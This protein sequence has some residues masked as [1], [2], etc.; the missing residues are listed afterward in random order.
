MCAPATTSGGSSAARKVSPSRWL[1]GENCRPDELVL[2]A[3]GMAGP[4][5]GSDGSGLRLA[6]SLGHRLVEPV[7]ALVPLRLR[8]DFLRKLKGVRFDGRGELR[9]GGE[10]LGSEA[11][12]FLFT[13]S[14]IS[15]L[16]V[17][18]LS[19][20]ASLALKNSSRRRSSSTCFPT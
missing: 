19:R 6:A 14:G 15:G 18:Q 10:V 12:E 20:A 13:D 3:G 4:Q 7:A 2:A 1:P 5:F 9:C 8:A 11:G 17:L 16:P